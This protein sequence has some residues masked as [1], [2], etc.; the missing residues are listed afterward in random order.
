MTKYTQLLLKGFLNML[1]LMTIALAILPI[2]FAHAQYDEQAATT[3]NSAGNLIQVTAQRMINRIEQDRSQINSNPSHV[4]KLVDEILL[5]HIDF[6]RMSRWVL[7]KYWRKASSNEREMFVEEFR[8]LV[9]RTYSIAL[10][11]FSGHE[12]I[13]LPV[14]DNSDPNSASVRTEIHTNNGPII[15]ISYDLYRTDKG[16]WKVYDVAIDG[17]S[18]VANYRSSFGSQIRRSGGLGKVINQMK[19]KNQQA[20]K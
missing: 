4:Y 12:I 17:I 1:R 5:P 15:P 10:L 6:M 18:L 20:K 14:R 11:E 3:S 7:G 8:T 13:F 9:I 2:S 16:P 19:A